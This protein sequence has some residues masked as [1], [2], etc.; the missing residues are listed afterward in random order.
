MLQVHWDEV[1]DRRKYVLLAIKGTGACMLNASGLC[2][3]SDHK[4][5]CVTRWG[6]ERAAEWATTK[7]AQGWH[8]VVMDRVY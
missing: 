6:Y 2:K 4:H 7:R 3:S 8:V 5:Y 1:V